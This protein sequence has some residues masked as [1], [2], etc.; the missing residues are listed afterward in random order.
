M[1]APE[2]T[3]RALRKRV[4][5]LLSAG[6]VDSILCQ[7]IEL[8]ARKIINPL[9][10]ALYSGDEE[11][12]WRAVLSVGAVVAH[13]AQEDMESAR[14]IMRR[15]MWSL[16]DESGGI[17]WGAPEAMGEIMARHE[18]LAREFAP[19]LISYLREDGNFLE[20]EA[21]QRGAVWAVARAGQVRPD[22][23]RAAGPH[24]LPYLESTDPA[25][26]GLAAWSLG[27]LG[28][29]GARNKLEALLAD[30]AEI[31][32]APEHRPIATRVSRLA[33]EALN[34]LSEQPA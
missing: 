14:V 33:R 8:P 15:F 16:N 21:L 2:R 18:G 4:A 28:F 30:H 1:E 26:R 20:L 6:D 12:R 13:L 22:L 23:F 24:L 11:T 25:V 34:A 3:G 17:G 29:R 9:I 27:V 19:I 10:L 7:L 5:G 32:I 31:I